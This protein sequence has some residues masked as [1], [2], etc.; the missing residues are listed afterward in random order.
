[1]ITSRRTRL[2]LTAT[3]LATG[4]GASLALGGV[5]HQNADITLKFGYVTGAAHPYGQAMKQFEANVEAASGGRVD[6]ALQA[7]Y[8]GGDDIQL[9][10]DIRGGG[11]QGGAVSSAVWPNFGVK[12]FE[13]LQFPFVLDS[14]KFEERII[15][16]SSGVAKRMLASATAKSN[17]KVLGIFEGGMRQ[18]A[19]KGG[20]I[21]TLA[22]LK[23]KKL[24]AVQA[25]PLQANMRALGIVPTPLAV[26]EVPLALTNGVVDGAEANSALVNTF[27]WDQAG[28]N[29]IT[30]INWFPFPAVV[31]MNKD[32]FAALPADIQGII[33]AEA[34]KLPTFS[35]QSVVDTDANKVT[36]PGILCA[37][38]VKYHKIAPAE[39][40]KMVAASKGVIANL[41]AKDAE[42]K[43]IYNTIARLKSKYPF[44]DSDLPADPA[45]I[46]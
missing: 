32:A 3:A 9:F 33:T 20:P 23:G 30:L 22:D 43:A 10:N 27:K 6:I 2:A 24:R 13:P 39:R 4:I 34:T 46:E 44:V 16:G 7:V 1:M 17:L 12:A 25:G 29:H 15:N 38:G 21:N 41:T 35:I 5:Q 26:G 36:V 42:V 37:R 14:Y 31:A 45:C 28:A 18:I 11:V 8:A 19:T 40:A